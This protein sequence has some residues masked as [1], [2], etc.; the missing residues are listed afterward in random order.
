MIDERN[1]SHCDLYT[2]C[3]ALFKNVKMKFEYTEIKD[4]YKEVE[5]FLKDASGKEIISLNTKIS[6]DLELWG[7]DVFFLINEFI[8]KYNLNFDKF[9][10][11][12]HFDSGDEFIGFKI[13]I[14]GLLKLPIAIVN[15]LIIK[16]IS[17]QTYK[18]IDNVLYDRTNEKKDLIFADLILSKLNGEFYL[19]ANCRIEL[20]K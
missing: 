8:E 1:K 15:G 19:R 4:A 10:H 20:A 13:L 5:K 16:F 12:K 14:S 11:D 18:R 7:D 2:Y 6:D 17:Q 9:E 3:N